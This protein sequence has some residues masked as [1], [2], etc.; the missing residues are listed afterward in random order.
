MRAKEKTNSLE[1]KVIPRNGIA[2][3]Q[4]LNGPL[5]QQHK[6]FLQYKELQLPSVFL[7]CNFGDNCILASDKIGLTRNILCEGEGCDKHLLVEWFRDNEDFFTRPIKSSD[8]RIFKVRNL[9]ESFSLV[10]V[11]ESISKCV[12]MPHKHKLVA[13]PLIHDLTI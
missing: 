2:K 13:V 12:L 8:L 3:K 6:Q 11:N 9:A 1:E 10:K 4:H 7:S 5:L